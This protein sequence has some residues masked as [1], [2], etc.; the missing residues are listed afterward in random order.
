MPEI[1]IANSVVMLADEHPEMGA[2]GPRAIGGS[3][4]SLMLCIPDVDAVVARAV[5]AGA[6][7]QRPIEDKFYGDR[8]GS[9]EDPFGHVW[10]VSTHVEDIAPDELQRRATAMAEKGGG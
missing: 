9:I 3:P 10:H 2:R 8:M 5:G 7:L 4:V 6:K 1:R